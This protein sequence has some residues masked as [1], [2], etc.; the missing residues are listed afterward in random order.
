MKIGILGGGALGLTAAY[1]LAQQGHQVV[2]LERELIVGGLASSFRVG[3]GRVG[4]SETAGVGTAASDQADEAEGSY[5][6]K[7]YHHIF[8]TD[9][10]IVSMIQE[11]GLG[12][13][14]YWGR[15][16]TSAVRHGEIRQLD[17]PLS[18]LLYKPLGFFARLRM[19]LATAYLKLQPD[20]RP[21]EGTTAADWIRRWEGQAAYDVVW[22]PLLTAKF[23]DY[24][25]KIAMPWFWS[26]VHLRTSSLGYL[27]GGFYQLYARLAER[28]RDLGGEI[29]LGQAVTAIEGQP[30][31]KV[32][33]ETRASAPTG[34][35]VTT[36]PTEYATEPAEPVEITEEFDA[37]ISTLPTRLF[38]KL[39][40]GLPEE[41][42]Q[43]HDW[44]DHY[45]AHCVILSLDR[46]LLTDGTYWLNVTDP[47]YPF[48]AVVEHTNF[49]DAADYD[50]QR[51]V[52]LG[53][54]LPMSS[55]R[56]RQS[57]EVIL[58]EFLPALKRI[59]S[60]FDESW[61]KRSW[62]FKAPFAQPIVTLDFHE[63]IPPLATPVANLYTANMFQVYP[64]DRGQNYSIKL[65]EEV[66]ALVNRSAAGRG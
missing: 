66:A 22:G 65:G 16:K 29:R 56:F 53:N 49:I 52:Y 42:R 3:A 17:D 48:L 32:R 31:G 18:V 19:G 55:P 1:R 6:E 47:G 9:R 15:P 20:H 39:A 24:S 40:R 43:K 44:G 10:V 7:F 51:L 61:V 34:G 8:K 26:R 36:R 11:L 4:A 33:V 45:G 23:G 28:V 27:R 59:R 2:I 64:Q 41:Y 35:A 46:Q 14:L 5:L 50:G 13:R 12:R 37:V 30:S 58:A 38:L 57:D 54:Y 21:L 63:H 62:V 25:Q 60:D